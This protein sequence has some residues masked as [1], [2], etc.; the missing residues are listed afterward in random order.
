MKSGCFS[1]SGSRCGL[2]GAW[3]GIIGLRIF[4]AVAGSNVQIA[5]IFPTVVAFPSEWRR[6][7]AAGRTRFGSTGRR[8]LVPAFVSRGFW[9][10]NPVTGPFFPKARACFFNKW[11]ASNSGD[12]QPTQIPVGSVSRSGALGALFRGMLAARLMSSEICF[13]GNIQLLIF[14]LSLGPTLSYKE[15]SPCCTPLRILSPPGRRLGTTLPPEA[16]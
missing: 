14:S 15:T 7:N 2:N 11:K 4:F 6:L 5:L 12:V 3:E 10:L 16:G 8:V 1:L 13:P 9:H